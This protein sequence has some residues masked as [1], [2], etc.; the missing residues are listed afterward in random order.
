MRNH[1]EAI[2]QIS[3]AGR[4]VGGVPC[5]IRGCGRAPPPAPRKSRAHLN[6]GLKVRSCAATQA[7]TET[8]D[9]ASETN[10]VSSHIMLK[11]AAG[12]DDRSPK[13]GRKVRTPQSSVPDN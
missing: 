1:P 10:D 4:T 3:L 12:P 11:L 5:R 8:H 6:A 7:A 13:G 2:G 9:Q